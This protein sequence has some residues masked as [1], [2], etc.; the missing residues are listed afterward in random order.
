M[1]STMGPA[2]GQTLPG[3]MYDLL[4]DF[5]ALGGYEPVRPP[6]GITKEVPELSRLDYEL[7]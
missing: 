7:C 2:M 3:Y 4:P 1:G 6:K 5:T